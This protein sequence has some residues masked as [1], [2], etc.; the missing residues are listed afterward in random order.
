MKKISTFAASKSTSHHIFR[1][2]HR[3]KC[4]LLCKVGACGVD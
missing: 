4:A 2:I 1:K 3:N